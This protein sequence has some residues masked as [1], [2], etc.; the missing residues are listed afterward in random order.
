MRQHDVGLPLGAVVATLR[1]RDR[2][3]ISAASVWPNNLRD[4]IRQPAFTLRKRQIQCGILGNSVTVDFK[5]K[6][7]SAG[8]SSGTCQSN[9]LSGINVCA[10]GDVDS[11]QVSV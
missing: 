5:M 10:I 8:V 6:V 11:F 1:H 3:A 9:L 2:R 4:L 7:R